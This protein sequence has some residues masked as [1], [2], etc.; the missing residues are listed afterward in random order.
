MLAAIDLHGCRRAALADPDTIRAFVQALADAIGSRGRGP[1]R[2]ERFQEDELDGWSAVQLSGTRSIA[3]RVGKVGALRF[4][5]VFACRPFDA[6]VAATVAGEH[7]GGTPSV[8]VLR[9]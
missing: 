5:D 7:F 3:V 6:Q 1:V 4:A 8:R 9:R 2:L